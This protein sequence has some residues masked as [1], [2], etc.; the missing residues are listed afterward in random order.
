METVSD[1]Q[2]QTR[3]FR[4]I[5]F[6]QPLGLTAVEILPYQSSLEPQQFPQDFSRSAQ[7]ENFTLGKALESC[8]VNKIS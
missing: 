4:A 1:T 5:P 2:I 3:D 7:M 6:R 8:S